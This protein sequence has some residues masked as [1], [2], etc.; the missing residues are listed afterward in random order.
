MCLGADVNLARWTPVLATP[1]TIVSIAFLRRGVLP[2]RSKAARAPV[3]ALSVAPPKLCSL[4]DEAL[5]S[6]SE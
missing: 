4:M 1:R 6:Q 5:P 2:H 3:P